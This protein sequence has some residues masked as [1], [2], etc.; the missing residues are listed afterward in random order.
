MHFY[1]QLLITTIFQKNLENKNEMRMYFI[2]LLE[3]FTKGD[4]IVL[5]RANLVIVIV[6]YIF[7]HSYICP[8][9]PIGLWVCVFGF[10]LITSLCCSAPFS[11]FMLLLI[12]FR[13]H[14]NTH[15]LIMVLLA[16]FVGT[17][18]RALSREDT[19]RS[20]EFPAQP[21]KQI[22]ILTT[23]MLGVRVKRVFRIA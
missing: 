20:I 17:Y 8:L 11:R 2:C 10:A 6:L 4:S 16:A 1:H 15:T 7:Q 21:T 3:S 19:A 14:T 23:L 22:Q 18:R 13:L 9:N 5:K 12:L